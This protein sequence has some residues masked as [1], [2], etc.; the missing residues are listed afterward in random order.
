MNQF[1]ALEHAITCAVLK[2]IH[3]VETTEIS[4]DVTN[5]FAGISEDQSILQTAGLAN[6]FRFFG[7]SSSKN[8]TKAAECAKLRDTYPPGSIRWQLED[9]KRKIWTGETKAFL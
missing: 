8:R 6:P 7:N 2:K 9:A 5:S 4:S 3:L 1:A